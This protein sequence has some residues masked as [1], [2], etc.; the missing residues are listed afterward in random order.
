MENSQNFAGS[1]ISTSRGEF[2]SRLEI[3]R[4]TGIPE[5]LNNN[6][7]KLC[8][9]VIYGTKIMGGATSLEVFEAKDTQKDSITNLN[10]AKLEA[11]RYFILQK[12]RVLSVTL[13]SSTADDAGMAAGAY[14]KADDCILNG[15]FELQVVGKTAVP[16]ISARVFDKSA[17]AGDGLVGCYELANPVLIAPQSPINATIRVNS[18]VGS[19]LTYEAVRVE[20]IGTMVIPA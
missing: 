10:N 11:G 1:R 6:Q 15:E 20:L 5:M 13:T 2:L 3:L 19:S 4:G 9:M 16:R 17:D 8:D 12:I 14:T 18:A 7:C